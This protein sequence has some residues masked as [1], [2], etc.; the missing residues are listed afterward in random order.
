MGNGRGWRFLRWS[1][2]Y[3]ADTASTWG[4][5][6]QEQEET[7]DSSRIFTISNLMPG[8]QS[9]VSYLRTKQREMNSF[10]RPTRI[11]LASFEPAPIQKVLR[12]HYWRFLLNFAVVQL[13]IL[14][15]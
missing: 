4:Q 14:D 7:M 12:S 8:L 11:S 3:C 15:I 6:G 13:G 10:Y 9:L 5:V 1:K 2:G